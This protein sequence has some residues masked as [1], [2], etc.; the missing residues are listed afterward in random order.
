LNK[1]QQ[2][3]WQKLKLV[4]RTQ[5]ASIGHWNGRGKYTE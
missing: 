4:T 5:G 3:S 1:I 2:K